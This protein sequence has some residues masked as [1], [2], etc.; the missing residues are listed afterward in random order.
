LENATEPHPTALPLIGYAEALGKRLVASVPWSP[1][2]TLLAVP[3]SLKSW[4]TTGPLVTGQMR[5]MMRCSI[6]GVQ[7]SGGQ[8]QA[9]GESHARRLTGRKDRS[10]TALVAC[11]AQAEKL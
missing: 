9:R 2:D 11:K 3:R 1:H 5:A 4:S 8:I 7:E 6:A 10:S